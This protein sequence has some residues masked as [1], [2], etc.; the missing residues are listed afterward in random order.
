MR[1]DIR[2]G[3]A[4][5]TEPAA[6]RDSLRERVTAERARRL[7]GL[8][9][10]VDGAPYDGDPASRDNLQGLLSA[11]AAGVPVPWPIAWRGADDV[12]RELDAA[13][14]AAVAGA[15]LAGVQAVYVASWYLKDAAIPALSDDELAAFDVTAPEH[16]T[17]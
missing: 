14:A 11:A 7:D 17:V 9:V 3:R 8:V 15:I 2:S 16:W 10:I 4:L 5:P 1:L 13:K 12:V 6:L